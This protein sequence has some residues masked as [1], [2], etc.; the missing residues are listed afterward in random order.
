M[1]TRR[2]HS[3]D[4]GFALPVVLVL[5][6]LAGIMLAVVLDRQGMQRQTVQ[7]EMRRYQSHH[8]E[9]GIREVVGAW[10]DTLAG[11]PIDKM[12]DDTGHA[13]DLAMPDGS[14]A[15]VYLFDGQGS[16][17]TEPTGLTDDEKV[18]A[19]GVLQQ[20]SLITGDNPN[21]AWLRPVGPIRVSIGAAPQE[22]L[23]AVAAYAAD[24]KTAKRF[25]QSI[26]DARAKGDVTQADLN[27]AMNAA[28]FKVE[29]QQVAQRLLTLKPEMWAMVVDS[30]DP[31]RPGKGGAPT[32][33]YLGRFTPP[34]GSTRQ[35]TLQTLG[36]FLS[37][38][39]LPVEGPVTP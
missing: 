21:P 39:E 4:C 17:V 35:S 1:S 3:S 31:T 9:Y 5:A 36:K 25:V 10:T 28:G 29:Q 18:D 24:D 30:Y 16:L 34:G 32:V 22:V 12:V 33:R 26:L 13:L 38:E 15:S 2:S 14:Y 23:E 7:A 37:W 11:Q 20:L 19:L 6:L 27:T 8:F